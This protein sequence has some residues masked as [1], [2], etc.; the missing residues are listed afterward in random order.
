MWEYL[1]GQKA[2]H[3]ERCS[4]PLA[5]EWA[6][7]DLMAPFNLIPFACFACQKRYYYARDVRWAAAVTAAL[8]PAA[9]IAHALEGDLN[10]QIWLAAVAALVALYA[11]IFVRCRIAG[12]SRFREQSSPARVDV[13]LN[14]LGAMA[15][16]AFAV[17]GAAVLIEVFVGGIIGPMLRFGL[18]LAGLG[19]TAVLLAGVYGLMHDLLTALTFLSG[20]VALISGWGLQ[21]IES[22]VAAWAYGL[23][24]V[25]GFSLAY[26]LGRRVFG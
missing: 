13:L 25:S 2:P 18:V 5:A 20:S 24:V 19:L 6:R 17:V 1:G 16:N 15:F 23:L 9:A 3:C 26:R 10:L 7:P 22:P 4:A 21:G 11:L 14:Y 12:G 8:L